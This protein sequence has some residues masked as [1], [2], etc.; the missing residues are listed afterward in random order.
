MIFSSFPTLSH[1]WKN[2]YLEYYLGF[3]KQK[4]IH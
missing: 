2:D 1:T 4:F 3:N